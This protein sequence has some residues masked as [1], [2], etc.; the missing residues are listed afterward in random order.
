LIGALSLATV[1]AAPTSTAPAP[2]KPVA[3][4]SPTEVRS[5]SEA[6]TKFEAA[7]RNATTQY[8]RDL[9]ELKKRLLKAENLE[10]ANAVNEAIAEAEPPVVC[11]VLNLEGVDFVDAQGAAKLT[12]LREVAEAEGVV[13]RLARVKPQVLDVLELDGLAETFG[14]D[15]IHRTLHQAVTDQLAAGAAEPAVGPA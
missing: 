2:R 12:E 5:L 13:L 11:I 7:R 15:H 4:S 8:V 1:A 9:Q 10:E 3:A 14:P 6:K